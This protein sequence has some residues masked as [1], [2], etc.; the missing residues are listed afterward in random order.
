[1][2]QA[3]PRRRGVDVAAELGA[4]YDAEHRPEEL[5]A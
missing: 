2:A 5:R 3:G 1:M 4:A